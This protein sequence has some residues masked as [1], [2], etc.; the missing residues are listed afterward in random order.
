[1]QSSK[2]NDRLQ[3]F[4]SVGVL[5]GLALVA[6]EIRQNNDLA[7]ADSVRV[8]LEGWQQIA[9]SEYETDITTL[10]VKSIREPQNLTLP[11]VGKL[12]AWLTN[13]MNQYML[14]F[15]MYGHGLG[16]SSGGVEYSPSD[17][18]AKSIDYYFG[19]RFGRSWYQENRY[20]IDAQIVEILDREL[21][22][23]PIQSGDSYLENIKSRLGVEPVAR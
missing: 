22:A 4:A 5:I 12:S 15:A 20:W 7:R 9:L 10:H 14:T 23:R 18:L 17:E 21:A 3:L 1:M 8:Q 13:V 19:G 6:Y 11:E 16:Y 2:L